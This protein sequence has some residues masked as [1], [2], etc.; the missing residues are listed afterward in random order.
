MRN[1]HQLFA[2]LT[3]CLFSVIPVNAA[4]S[5]YS[6]GELKY[7]Y[8]S[9]RHYDGKLWYVKRNTGWC[10]CEGPI[11][12]QDGNKMTFEK[13]RYK[14]DIVVPEETTITLNQ[15]PQKIKIAG[16]TGSFYK[17][18]Q[19]V[20]AITLPN[21]IKQIETNTFLGCNSLEKI[22][23]GNA[24][25]LIGGEAFNGCTSLKTVTYNGCIYQ[26]GF[27]LPSTLL[28]LGGSA[29]AN[30]K[31]LTGTIT[32]PNSITKM[33]GNIFRECTGINKIAFSENFKISE[34]PAYFCYGCTGLQSIS[35]SHAITS[36][37]IN[38]FEGCT[39]L[40]LNGTLSLGKDLETLGDGA[41]KNTGFKELNLSSTK[42]TAIPTNAFAECANLVNITWQGA[43]TEIGNMAF[44]NCGTLG[45][46]VSLL[47][48]PKGLEKIGNKAFESCVSLTSVN[49][50]GT[51]LS[52]IGKLAFAN[53]TS[54]LSPK[55]KEGLTD[56]GEQAFYKCEALTRIDLPATVKNVRKEAFRYCSSLTEGSCYNKRVTIIDGEVFDSTDEPL[57]IGDG[58]FRDT[59]LTV[60]EV[61]E[62]NTPISRSA[63]NRGGIILGNEVFRD[64]KNLI[65]M[66]E[67]VISVGNNAFENCSAL[68]EGYIPDGMK[69]V[70]AYLF[71]YA[72]NLKN[73]NIPGSVTSINDYAF[74]YCRTLS[75]VNI[76]S[77]VT[78][79]GN[80]A[81]GGCRSLT[82]IDLPEKVCHIGDYAFDDLPLTSLVLPDSITTIGYNAF[83]GDKLETLSIGKNEW[84]NEDAPDER[85]L[86]IGKYNFRYVRKLTE[87]HSYFHIPPVMTDP[88]N[89][90]IDAY[91]TATLYVP[92]GT[93]QL[94]L[95]A[96]GWKN[97][98]NIVEASSAGISDVNS[99]ANAV[100]FNNGTLN[101]LA[102]NMHVS[103]FAINGIHIY[104]GHGSA[105]IDNLEPGIYIVK[106][107]S[108]AK[109]VLLAR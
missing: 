96:E 16:I 17:G 24:T 68:T 9:N 47:D 44:Y 2:T 90:F 32:L 56:I 39:N 104:K 31:A 49:F 55:F 109:K 81:F 43:I 88:E 100:Y 12:L 75:S 51:K 92:D 80:N 36:I 71:R 61:I 42:L 76:P 73:V 45:A 63:D 91:D 1:I 89:S 93:K 84:D 57:E 4:E 28:T 95:E 66:P 52:T 64:C 101:I 78:Y 108:K 41:F 22:V 82:S 11:N 48:L 50:N 27:N 20:T 19:D 72:E 94:Y 14:G 26:N 15:K 60:F 85:V 65:S 40:Y 86:T 105:K 58:N 98:K 62:R 18:A 70:P 33:E 30:C 99:D 106:I 59:P 87:I 79:I 67:H 69:S 25:T 102:P 37:G 23:L 77:S 83:D 6:D 35:Y 46:G 53:C 13:E 3:V 29:F 54:L 10:V 21:S 103:V 107:G 97:F 5:D 8:S 34:I 38:A 74:Y 7:G